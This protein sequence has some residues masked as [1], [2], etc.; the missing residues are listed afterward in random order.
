MPEQ[1]M[2]AYDQTTQ[3][4]ANLVA[5]RDVWLEKDTSET[6]QYGRLLRYVYIGDVMVNE[7]MLRL[8]MAQAVTFPPDVKHIDRF[9]VVQQEA[10]AAG[11]GLWA[12]QATAT[13]EPT[14]TPVPPAVEPGQVVVNPECSQFDAPGNN[15]NDN[16][17]EEYICLTNQGAQSID[18]TGWLVKDEKDHTYVFPAFTLY[19]AAS[20]RVRTGCGSN[21]QQD[22]YWCQSGSAVWNN[23]GDTVFL[24]DGARNLLTQFSY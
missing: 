2:P 17:V 6:D 12:G 10:Q 19:P 5:D 11:V 4:N 20:V 3:A 13:P 8:G 18:M 23:D 15:D 21:T 16:L 14:V 1:G 24:F 7:E 9:L 22:L